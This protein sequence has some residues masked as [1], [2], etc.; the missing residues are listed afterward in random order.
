MNPVAAER[1]ELASVYDAFRERYYAF[2]AELTKAAEVTDVDELTDK[3]RATEAHALDLY[4]DCNLEVL[5]NA[6]GMLDTLFD[7]LQTLL[8]S[9]ATTALDAV[10]GTMPDEDERAEDARDLRGRLNAAQRMADDA[11]TADDWIAVMAAVR[12]VDEEL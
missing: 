2:R 8:R 7:D 11:R 1:A 6:D 5:K 12:T 9:H 3:M 10:H 4:A